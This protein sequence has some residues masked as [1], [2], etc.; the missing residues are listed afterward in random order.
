[1]KMDREVIDYHFVIVRHGRMHDILTFLGFL[2]LYLGFAI[3]FSKFKALNQS[4]LIFSN[5][6]LIKL[7]FDIVFASI[8]LLLML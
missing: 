2:S 3:L 8:F 7:E 6:L 4:F 5:C 1:M